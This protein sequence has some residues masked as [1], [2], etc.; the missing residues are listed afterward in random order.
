M[1]IINEFKK[2]HAASKADL[3]G[4]ARSKARIVK[5]LRDIDSSQ[6]EVGPAKP[7]GVVVRMLDGAPMRFHSDGSL[8][9]AMGFKPGKKVRKAMKKARRA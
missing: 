7:T 1:S 4:K 8:R 6:I 3:E 2:H 5:Q 9:H